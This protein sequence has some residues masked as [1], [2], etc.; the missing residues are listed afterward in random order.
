MDE[1]GI[2]IKCSDHTRV[3]FITYMNNAMRWVCESFS[4]QPC[5][6]VDMYVCLA[7]AAV[8]CITHTFQ[9]GVQLHPAV[10]VSWTC[11]MHFIIRSSCGV[12][13]E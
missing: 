10:L 3:N 8:L 13:T 6:S 1:Y 11:Q 12:G 7:G 5:R 4:A 2:R 9:Y